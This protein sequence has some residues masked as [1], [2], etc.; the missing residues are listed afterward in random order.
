V[1][2]TP[3]KILG[4]AKTREGEM[5]A[6]PRAANLPEILKVGRFQGSKSRGRVYGDV[7][8]LAALPPTKCQVGLA[9]NV[10]GAGS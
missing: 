6:K 1:S 10:G 2:I 3:S 9:E 8:D 7:S 5:R 4:L